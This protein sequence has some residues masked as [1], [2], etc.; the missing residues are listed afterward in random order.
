MKGYLRTKVH[1]ALSIMR[2]KV[3]NTLKILKK[4]LNTKEK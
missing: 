2:V 4:I 1:N 3:K